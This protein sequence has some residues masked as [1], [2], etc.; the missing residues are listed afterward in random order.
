MQEILDNTNTKNVDL[1]DPGGR[2]GPYLDNGLPDLRNLQLS[3]TPCDENDIIIVLS[4]T[5]FYNMVP[6]PANFYGSPLYNSHVEG[7]VSKLMEIVQ[8]K[9]SPSFITNSIMDINWN[10]TREMRKAME[11]YPNRRVGNEIT[12]IIGNITCITT[13]IGSSSIDATYFAPMIPNN[14]DIGLKIF[15]IF[16]CFIQTQ[17]NNQVFCNPWFIILEIFLLIA[18]MCLPCLIYQWFP[19]KFV[20]C[21]YRLFIPILL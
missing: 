8:T 9:H 19:D 12:G 3:F 5:A 15:F 4:S 17:K 16:I 1:K 14:T 11:L 20:D 13:L 18:W 2:L 10:E 21:Y 6:A 7:C